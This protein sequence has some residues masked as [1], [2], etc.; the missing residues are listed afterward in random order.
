M[1][2]N[3]LNSIEPRLDKVLTNHNKKAQGGDQQIKIAKVDIDNLGDLSSKYNV[4]A[5]PTGE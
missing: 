1:I 2:F 3:I 5:V 4:Q